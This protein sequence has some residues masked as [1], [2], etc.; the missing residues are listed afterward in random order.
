[1]NAAALKEHILEWS[2]AVGFQD[3]RFAHS[4]HMEQEAI[5]L[6]EWLSEGRHGEMNYLENYFD[7]RTD[8]SKLV[9]GCKTVLVFAHNY[10]PPEE[11]LS[12]NGL[13]IARYAYGRDYHKV[14]KK[15]L[16]NIYHKIQAVHPE[17]EGRFFVDSGPVL[18]RDWA[19]KSGLGWTG[20]NTLTIHPKRGSYFFL[21]V[22]L[23]NI[24]FP[25]DEPI[26]D[27]CGTCRKCIDACPTD[28]ID[29]EGYRLDASK[30]ISYL[31][32][33][34]K[35]EQLPEKF[36]N[37]MENWIFGCDICQEVC[38]WN[39]FSKPHSETDFLPSEELKQ[40][41][42]SDWKDLSVE[43]FNRLFKGS[44]VKRTKYVG[45]KRNIDFVSEDKL[46]Q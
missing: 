38:P 21:A 18:E 24:D 28:A 29:M 27:H 41:S 46:E 30:C 10:Y 31:T 42:P 15:K 36:R 11:E 16:K 44:A 14:I 3:V 22:M 6:E 26:R 19:R 45:L 7:K 33:E 34:L 43:K 25:P 17:A 39:K 23:L 8:P 12:K 40:M 5:H 4:E 37:Q 32:I 20:K 35:E 1:M 13:K 2:D 9:P